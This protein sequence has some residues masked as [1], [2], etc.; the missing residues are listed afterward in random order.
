MYV[1]MYVCMYVSVCLYVCMY[2]CMYV[3]L[4]D[5]GIASKFKLLSFNMT[6]FAV[7]QIRSGAK[8]IKPWYGCMLDGN[9]KSSD[10]FSKLKSGELDKKSGPIVE[11]E[12]VEIVDTF[13]G[14]SR[15]NVNIRLEKN[16]PIHIVKS[17]IGMFIEF[18]INQ[19]SN[20]SS[21]VERDGFAL[22]MC[23]AR[24]SHCLPD[25]YKDEETNSKHRLQNQIISWLRDN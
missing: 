13:A 15:D 23:T 14:K 21:I 17:K 24:N 8:V 12:G 2:V 18:R 10:L 6:S 5:S 19:V 7:V 11:L 4:N 3:S 22:L 9:M 1:C 16:A 25:T 20:T